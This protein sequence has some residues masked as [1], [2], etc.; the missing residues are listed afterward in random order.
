META[1]QLEEMAKFH[2]EGGPVYRNP[3]SNCSWSCGFYRACLSIND[4]GNVAN[5]LSMFPQ[6]IYEE[7]LKGVDSSE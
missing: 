2:K 1:I 6:T 3:T 5:A 7:P 4:D